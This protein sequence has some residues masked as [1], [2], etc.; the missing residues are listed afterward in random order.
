MKTR[1]KAICIV[2]GIVLALT[3]Y[4]L[5]PVAMFLADFRYAIE[6]KDA[7]QLHKYLAP[8]DAFVPESGWYWWNGN[9]SQMTYTLYA[10][11]YDY[12]YM[13]VNGWH[14]DGALRL[15]LHMQVRVTMSADNGGMVFHTVG[16]QKTRFFARI[17]MF[18]GDI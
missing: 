15:Q 11:D 2:A 1:W 18:E 14:L 10:D 5:V 8:G 13:G 12:E 9:D 4:M 3:A 7:A 17:V 16:L 6:N